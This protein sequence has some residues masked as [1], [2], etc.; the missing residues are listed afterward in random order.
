MQE[1]EKENESSHKQ[2]WRK[3]NFLFQ[4]DDTPVDDRDRAISGYKKYYLYINRTFT[5]QC[6]YQIATNAVTEMDISK[7]SRVCS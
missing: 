3:H 5:V 1:N 6:E 7:E 2:K 4:T